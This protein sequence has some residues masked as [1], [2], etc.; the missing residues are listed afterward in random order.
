M[1]RPDLAGMTVNERLYNLGLMDKWDEAVLGR[2]RETMLTI[3][4]ECEVNPPES[5]VDTV[6]ANPAKYGYRM[7]EAAG[8]WKPA[9]KDVVKQ[10]VRDERADIHADYLPLVDSYLID[11]Y[12][13]VLP[14]LGTE[15]Q[16]FVVARSL[17]HVVYFED[18][19]E[20][21]GTAREVDGRL[22]DCAMYGPLVLAVRVLHEELR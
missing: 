16:A 18:V 14:R 11:P 21:F 10:I 19:E 12:P 5:T 13:V 8:T 3:M 17:T 6:L 4:R 1:T 15:E 7:P 22:V 9:T 20:I 2:D